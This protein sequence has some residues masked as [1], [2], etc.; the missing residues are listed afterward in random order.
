MSA[1]TPHDSRVA[2]S[3]MARIT[4]TRSRTPKALARRAC[5]SSRAR[6]GVY[7]WDSDGNRIL[8]GMA[9]LWCVN[10]GYG[11]QELVDAATR[12]L[13]ELPYYNSFFQTSTPS[14]IELAR[15][16]GRGDAA[17]ARPFLLRQ[18][19]LGS[20]RHR[21]P[22]RAPL[23]ASAGQAEQAHVHRP[24]AGVSRQH[25]R[26]REPRRHAAHARARARR[27]CPSSRTSRIR[28]GT[29]WAASCRA[30][31]SDS[32]SARALEEKILELG[33]GQ[34]RRVHRRA[35]AGRRRRDRSA[36]D[37]LAGDSADLSQVRRAAG[38]RR[39]HLRFRAHRPVVRLADVSAS[40]RTSCRWPRACPRAIC[41]SPPSR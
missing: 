29:R 2:G 6:E 17:R 19:R 38:R 32:S 28:T 20:E 30:R 22:P 10:V 5:A 24:H 21:H 9:G 27:C 25:A 34:R 15:G 36:A 7:V 18:L 37:V 4:C 33:P 1:F 3:S 23:L 35:G 16:A 14:Q 26:G 41:R 13:Q 11:R 39:S 8:D 40:S 31:S 12:Q